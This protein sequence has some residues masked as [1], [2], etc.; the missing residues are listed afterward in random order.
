MPQLHR[1]GLNMSLI[2]VQDL[3]VSYGAN[4]VLRHVNMV[5]DAGEIVTIVGGGS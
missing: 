3:S 4:T 2:T 1:K 5:V